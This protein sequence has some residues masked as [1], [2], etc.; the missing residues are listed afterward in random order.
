[1]TTRQA[2][3]RY[4]HAHLAEWG[5]RPV[6]VFNPHNKP[7]DDLPVIY[8]FNNGG[9]PGWYSAVLIAEDGWGA[10]GHVCSH[11]SYMPHDLGIIE[12]SRSDRHETFR[13]HFPNGYRMAFV[14][15]REVPTH[16][17]LAAAYAANQATKGAGTP[18]AK[19]EG[20][21]S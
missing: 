18:P 17:G 15:M 7:V 21:A 8:G 10:G 11:E 19:S 20:S 3:A 9:E 5:G 4:L 2:E 13:A 6:T 14:P 16:K 12:G 1:M